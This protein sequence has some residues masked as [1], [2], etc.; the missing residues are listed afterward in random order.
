MGNSQAS[1]PAGVQWLREGVIRLAEALTFGVYKALSI[2]HLR[3][4]GHSQSQ[5]VA[6]DTCISMD[7]PL[8][9]C[10]D[11]LQGLRIVDR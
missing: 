3:A 2:F 11:S 9:V 10:Q 5:L 6:T 1:S 8:L 7:W 4:E